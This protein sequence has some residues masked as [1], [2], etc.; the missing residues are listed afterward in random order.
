MIRPIIYFDDVN[1]R[2]SLFHRRAF[3]FGGAA[4]LGVLALG[5]RLA[6]LQLLEAARYQT[7][8]EHN[9]FE[10]LL[11][12]PPRGL[13]LDR[14]GVVLASNR[15]DF[16]LLLAKDEH[17]DVDGVLSRL[18]VLIPMDDARRQRL[19]ADIAAAPRKAPVT[20]L[21]DMTWEQFSAVN[22]RAPELPGVTADMGEV[23]VYPFAAAFAHV[24]GYVAKVSARDIAKTGPNAEPILLNPGFRIGKQGIEKAYDLPLRGTAGARKVE[25]DVKGRVVRHDPAGDIA[26]IPGAPIKLTLDADIQNRALEVFGEESGAAVM[27][28]CRGG[29]LLCLLSAPSFD[30]NRFV[31]GLTGPE[32]R[33]LAGYERKPLFNKA[34]TA[35]YPPGSTF[36][37]MVALAALEKGIDPA[38]THTCNGAWAWGGRV[39]HCDKAHGTLDMHNA[40]K[41]SCDIYFYQTALATGP[42]RIAAMAR[43]FGLGQTFDIGIPGQK[44]GL[45]PDR[46]Y[47]RRAFPRD[48][49]W[50]PGETPSMGIGQGYVSVN[51]LQLAVMV[52]R[53]ANGEKALQPRLVRQV[54]DRPGPASAAAADLPV[55]RA[56]LDFVRAAMASVANDVGGT[57]YGAAQL[58]LGPIKMAGKTGTAQAHSYVGGHGEHGARGAWA[59]RDHAWFVAFAPYDDPRY[60]LAVLVEHGG[61]GAEAAAPKAAQLMRVALLKDPEIRARIVQPLPEAPAP[62]LGPAGA[63]GAAT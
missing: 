6:D 32:Y 45:V 26:S 30:A 52:A 58:G 36:K 21:E 62:S 9:E 33:A 49:V 18:A 15:P 25:V 50:H 47:K 38:T 51:A 4:G 61:F 53:L 60:A 44:P 8:S 27:L 5:G 24:V 54:G 37:T 3:L 55:A 40:I 12:A 1:E 20:V 31:K 10:F 48:P 35:T 57:G 28:D 39:W 7:A 42:D 22:V 41:T 63:S 23:R 43:R 34:L 19:A 2:Q 13:I 29:D 56:H 11:T 59:L 16:R 46:A 14:D 17:T